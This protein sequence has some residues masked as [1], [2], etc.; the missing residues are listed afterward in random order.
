MGSSKTQT[1]SV[2]VRQERP[3]LC[4]VFADRMQMDPEKVLT[5]LQDTILPSGKATPSQVQAF[6]VVSNQ[7]GLNPFTKEIY[8]FPTKGG[9]VQ[10]IIGVD[11][12][13]SLI[14]RQEGLDGIEFEQEDDGD[15]SLVS[16]TCRIYRKDMSRPVAIT[17]YLSEC[18]R[19]TEP[20]TRWPHRMLRHKAL[21]QCARVAFGLSGVVDEDEAERMKEVGV[22][23]VDE[24][25]QTPAEKLAAKRAERQAAQRVADEV[26][27]NQPAP[28]DEAAPEPEEDHV[29]DDNNMVEDEADAPADDDTA[30]SSP[31]VPDEY[32]RLFDWHETQGK[33]VDDSLKAVGLPVLAEIEPRGL[34]D[35]EKKLLRR[36]YAKVAKGLSS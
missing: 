20:W 30:D 10:P 27:A 31:D 5:V 22:I 2:A 11:G 28:D 13:I 21:T 33:L 8:A 36:A 16:I 12:W 23:V 29:V 7:Y 1:R 15:G 25:E 19:N 35:D 17:E 14:H 9:G 34:S 3:K 24:E 26:E 6:L 4:D 32:M 18:Q